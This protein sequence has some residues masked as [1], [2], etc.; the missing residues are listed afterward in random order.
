[1]FQPHAQ[2]RTPHGVAHIE[3]E[4]EVSLAGVAARGSRCQA[5]SNAV[6]HSTYRQQ[7]QQLASRLTTPQPQAKKKKQRRRPDHDDSAGK[8][9]KHDKCEHRQRNPQRNPLQHCDTHVTRAHLIGPLGENP[10]HQQ[11]ETKRTGNR[12]IVRVNEGAVN[13]LPNPHEI[14][15]TPHGTDQ[16]HTDDQPSH[17]VMTMALAGDEMQRSECR[18]GQ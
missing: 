14:A 4:R 3:T 16:T 6:R 1:M 9:C 5:R 2:R 10:G 11:Q 12:K 13:S 18:K 17:R 15:E 7:D 8:R